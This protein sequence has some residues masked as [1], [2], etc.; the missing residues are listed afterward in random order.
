MWI[1]LGAGLLA[2]SGLTAAG[3]ASADSSD[4]T[5]RDACLRAAGYSSGYGVGDAIIP[6]CASLGAVA[7]AVRAGSGACYWVENSSTYPLARSVD[8]E[9][10]GQ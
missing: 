1:Q 8:P 3:V 7:S 6:E 5:T 2:A 4:T 9:C 10:D